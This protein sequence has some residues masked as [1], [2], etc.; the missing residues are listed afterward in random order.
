MQKIFF[1]IA[2][3]CSH[4]VV[5][6]QQPQKNQTDE[7]KQEIRNLE[8][9]IKDLENEI[10]LLE[11]SDPE[12]AAELK[13][14]LAVL[15]SMLSM[16]GGAVASANQPAKSTLKNGSQLKPSTSPLVPITIKQ[17][18]TTPTAAQA[19]DRLLWYTGKKLNDSTLIT[20]KGLLVQYAEK[21]SLV[22]VQPPKKT[23]RFEKMVKELINNE[24]RKEELA[25]HFVNMEN[26]LL[27]Y[28]LLVSTMAIY[29]D[30]TTGYSNVIKN[31]IE[32]PV[33]EQLPTGAGGSTTPVT[34]ETKTEAPPKTPTE[35]KL[36]PKKVE[37]ASDI[38]KQM[39]DQLAFAKK[40]I[41]QLPPIAE[42]PAP[43]ARNL[44][45]CA[46]CDTSLLAR[47][48][49][50]DSIWLEKYHGQ[51]S[52]IA[53]LLL[54]L[55]RQKYLLGLMDTSNYLNPLFPLFKRLE[56]KDNILIEKYGND[57]HY[58]QILSTVVLGHERQSQLIGINDN[59]SPSL[60][61]TIMSKANYAYKKYYNEQVEA[62]NH[63]FV[64]NIPFHLG[65]LRQKALLGI[66]EDNTT[67]GDM[68]NT[69]MEYN[70]FALTTEIDFVYEQINDEKEIELK[71]SG[72]ME[73]S[74]K[75]YTM[76]VFDSCTYKMMPYSTDIS[77]QSLEKVT[78]P[79]SVKS[80]TKTIRDEENKLVTYQYS[81]P[82]S[83][84][85]QFP[86]FRIDLCNTSRPDTA[87]M[88]GFVGNEETAQQFKSAMS[89]IN[90]SYKADILIYANYVF[91]AG[92]V[93]EEG[94]IDMGYDILK[95]IEGFQNLDPATTH[96]GKLKQQYEGKKQMDI[97]RQ[98]MIN[99]LSNDK[100]AFLFTANNKSTVFTDKYND[101]K[102]K[103]EDY[104]ELK[105]G[106]IHLRI[107][108]EPVR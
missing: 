6:A 42:F 11:K 38:Q 83:F 95:T 73:S 84:P 72:T 10:K 98:G 49:R 56:Q 12:E 28:P 63:D 29:D 5:Q 59:E 99:K 102:K 37:L 87:F 34:Q 100:T 44:G 88:T 41:Q 35:K 50:E 13:K 76:L 107:V 54:G 82:E 2:F 24:K 27:Y 8:K 86:E 1:I 85:L 106:Q 32:L 33:L 9:E 75:K 16:L 90:K 15:K 36:V 25:E 21:K 57:F 108:H 31:T 4:I 65:V 40:L 64:L 89:Q 19:K 30:L 93:D 91:Y 97:H 46:T 61:H 101:F 14:E 94:A 79:M 7:M 104:T 47:K 69:M 52:K 18:V 51:E 17:P 45:L 39:E 66:E 96:M 3:F 77:T 70:R 58:T 20:V 53:N 81:G 62:K 74:V 68:I 67:L 23:D 103:I 22:I 43:P 26:G 92:E 55:E 71:V 48:R 80:G 60:L 78:I 105:R